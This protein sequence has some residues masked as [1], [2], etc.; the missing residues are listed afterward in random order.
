MK[1]TDWPYDFASLPYWENR[2]HIP[3]VYDEYLEIRQTDTLCCVYSIAEVTM[4]TY[5]GFLA[6]LKN[7]QSPELI[8]NITNG[9]HFLGSISANSKGDLLFLQGDLYHKKSNTIV[10]PVVIIDVVKNVFA[11]FETDNINPCYRVIELDENTFG[12]KADEKQCQSDQ[13]LAA[14]SR[15]TMNLK[16]LQWYDY[17]EFHMLPQ[18]IFSK[19]HLFPR[20][21]KNRNI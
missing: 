18:K 1:T 14:L 11:F 12:F 15:K 17:T 7:K 5:L 20:L 9:I 8:L 3:Y 10:R 4:G 2:F 21:F 6:V 13:R 16:Q 19:K